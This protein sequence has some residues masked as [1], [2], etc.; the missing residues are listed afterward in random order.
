MN[1]LIKLFYQTPGLVNISK[2]DDFEPQPGVFASIYINL[3]TP[4]SFPKVRKRIVKIISQNID[5]EVDYICGMESG[6]SY[7]ASA[8]ADKTNKK[9]ILFRKDKKKY[10]IKNYFVGKLPKKSDYVV[11]V[12]DVISSGNTVSKAT[13][14]LLKMGCKVEVVTIFSYTWHAVIAKNLGIKII[15]LCNADELIEYGMKINRLTEYNI[16]II[17][18]FIA[19]EENRLAK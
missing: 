16:K 19:R 15:S 10:N 14:Q 6:G 5:K 11:I 1:N 9:V 17:R 13:S 7:Y 4:L 8:V 3:K 12:D 18:D 2:N